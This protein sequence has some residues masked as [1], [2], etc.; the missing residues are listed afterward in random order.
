MRMMLCFPYKDKLCFYYQPQWW[1]DLLS[2]YWVTLKNVRLQKQSAFTVLPTCR[3]ELPV[4]AAASCF[5]IF[6]FSAS[7]QRRKKHFFFC[8]QHKSTSSPFF[9]V[10]YLHIRFSALLCTVNFE[11]HNQIF[12]GSRNPWIFFFFLFSFMSTKILNIYIAVVSQ[13]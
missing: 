11:V 13:G 10:E 3:K 2:E 9:T 7:L 1:R 4:I 8:K 6:L 5:K 12:E